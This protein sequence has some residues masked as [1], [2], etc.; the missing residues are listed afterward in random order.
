MFCEKPLGLA[1]VL[2]LVSGGGR[3]V[4]AAA[5]PGSDPQSYLSNSQFV[6][7]F[8]TQDFVP[9][10][11]LHKPAW[12]GASWVKFDHD[13][14]NPVIF[15]QSATEIASLWTPAYAYFAFRCK[16]T[17]LNLFEGK[18][19]SKD[20]WTLWDR[21]VVEIFL[22]PQPERM[23]HYYEFEVA[24]NNLWI[25]LEIDLD[26][27]PF[28]NPRW[29]SGFAHATSIDA[30][31]HVWTCELRIPV[32]ALAGTTPLKANTDWRINFFRCDGPGN[33]TQRRLLSWSPVH[34]EAHTFHSPWSFGV[35]RFVK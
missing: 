33:E 11:N 28:G 10:G 3:M 4:E 24:P 5:V 19:P 26:K 18:D 29:D 8:T 6:S 34:S 15:S 16:Y 31:N 17:T 13:A 32:A 27:K 23:R 9:D 1:M 21:D 22:N 2:I 20:F 7:K 12:R 14:F 30:K 25:D 35:I